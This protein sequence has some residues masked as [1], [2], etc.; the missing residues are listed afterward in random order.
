VNY[1]RERNDTPK[2]VRQEAH[3]AGDVRKVSGPMTRKEKDPPTSAETGVKEVAGLR[4]AE[5]E[6]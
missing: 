4:P 1:P 2:G 3:K 5:I 6:A